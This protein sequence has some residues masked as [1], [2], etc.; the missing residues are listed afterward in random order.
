[1]AGEDGSECRIPHPFEHPKDQ[2]ADRQ[3]VNE[4]ASSQNQVLL[5][6]GTTPDARL[7]E[8]AF[9]LN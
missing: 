2:K 9:V 3:S 7:L 1:M 6:M 4:A 5:A 8:K